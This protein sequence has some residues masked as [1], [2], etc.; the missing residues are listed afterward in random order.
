[1]KKNKGLMT[2]VHV[3]IGLAIVVLCSV[4]TPPAPLTRFGLTVIGLFVATNYWFGTV[5]MI[6]S[7]IL[8]LILFVLFTGSDAAASASA[9][10]GGTTV[11]QCIMLMPVCGALKETGATEVIAKWIIS[12]KFLSGKPLLFSYVFLF[13]CFIVGVLTGLSSAVILAFV[14]FDGVAE[15]T[16]YKPGEKYY[17]CMTVSTFL[18]AAL[19]TTVIPYRSYLTAMVSSMG[20]ILGMEMNGAMYVIYAFCFMVV[21][22]ALILLVMKYILRVDMS[23]LT[24]LDTQVLAQNVGKITLQGKLLLGILG[25][26]IL[27]IIYPLI[28][29]EG[30]LFTLLSK[31]LTN[32]LFFGAAAVL[33]C[34]IH[35]DNKPLMDIGKAT[36][37]Y[38]P[39]GLLFSMGIMLFY[40]DKMSSADSGIRDFLSVTMGTLF[41]GMPSWL[42]LVCVV[43]ITVVVT[44]FFSN[45]A[46]GIVMLTAAAPLAGQFGVD[47]MFLAILVMFSSMFGFLTPGGNGMT[48]LLYGKEEVSSKEIY[49]CL[50]PF[51]LVFMLMNVV[52]GVIFGT[53]L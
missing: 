36:T 1:M 46:T 19:G 13:A 14:L 27:G 22:L 31:T 34:I 28:V 23:K 30:F 6:W 2:L 50:I 39:W 41:S 4:L 3:L 26:V 15:T 38:V 33:A 35:V 49:F 32:N 17:S 37:R 20:K 45:M 25:I 7:S 9:M 24:Q 52:L 43:A 42:F 48:P 16:G 11:W 47:P 18:A 51:M 12:R 40:A 8:S 44:G 29:K 10:L 5:G 53:L 21:F